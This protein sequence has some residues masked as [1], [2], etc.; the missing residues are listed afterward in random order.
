MIDKNLPYLPDILECIANLSNDEVFTPPRLVNQ[1]LDMLPSHLFT[2]PHTTF[3]DPFTKSGVF[4]RE[5]AERL[6][7]GLTDT[8]PDNQQRIDH[9][10][11][12]QLFG[13]ATSELSALMARRSV[14]RAKAANNP[15]Y[16]VS[17]VFTTEQG[18][19]LYDEYDHDWQGTKC[20]VCGVSRAVYDRGEHL[21]KYAYPFLHMDLKNPHF[22]HGNKNMQFDV[23][24][25]NPPYQMDDGGAQASAKPLYHLFVEQAKKLKPRYLTMIIPARWY[26]GGKGLDDFRNTMIHDTKIS[27]LVDYPKASDCFQGVEIKGGVCYFLWDRDKTNADC[28]VITKRQD[29]ADNIKTR[30]LKIDN[31]DILIR[32]NDSISILEK[33]QQKQ[34][35]I[36]SDRG[37]GGGYIPSYGLTGV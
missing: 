29:M 36:A 37:G 32:N 19:I 11:K 26:A 8:I 12:H 25:G 17:K 3:F 1:M 10:F 22:E 16:A 33:I 34:S 28:M 4:L 20:A 31:T 35:I 30:P 6:N 14:Y 13:V 15:V 5:I 24:I 23:I 27:H 18:N 7:K 21:E 2:C 9:I